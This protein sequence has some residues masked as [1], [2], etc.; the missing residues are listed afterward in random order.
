[1]S[2]QRAYVFKPRT[3]FPIDVQ[4]AGEELD[5]LK[6]HNSGDLTP[7]VVVEAAKSPKNPLHGAFEW[8]DSKAAHQ[9][10]LATAGLLIRSIVVLVTKAGEEE[11][12]S[13]DVTVTGAKGAGG[14]ATARV[15]PPEE[16]HRQRVE[17]GWRELAEWRHKFGEV[18]EFAAV[19][20]MIDG[21]L[22][23]HQKDAKKKVA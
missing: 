7:D 22:A 12:K 15:V 5:R 3:S 4:K 23:S 20:A 2:E 18:A 17:S 1:M 13:V 16:L 19:A 6:G 8:D 14:I 21:L 9:H 10:R 11:N